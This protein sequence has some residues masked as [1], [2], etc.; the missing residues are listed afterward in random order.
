MIK[1]AQHRIIFMPSSRSRSDSTLQE[2]TRVSTL[3]TIIQELAT[4]GNAPVEKGSD[5]FVFQ[6]SHKII[7]AFW[8][9]SASSRCC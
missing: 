1:Q 7:A 8:R 6:L 5:G 9:P 3:E 2:R 4:P